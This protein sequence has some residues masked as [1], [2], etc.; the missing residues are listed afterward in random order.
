[1]GGRS[2]NVQYAKL[3]ADMRLI[4]LKYGGDCRACGKELP[5]G[6]R[7][8]WS[9][10]S[11][12]VWCKGCILEWSGSAEPDAGTNTP[13]DR[14]TRL[15]RYLSKCVL[16]EA[17]NTLASYRDRDR[18]WF[19]HYGRSEL[20]VTGE[21]DST[22]VPPALRRH[23]DQR[24]DCTFIYGWPTLVATNQKNH[25]VIAPL[26]LV[27]VRPEHRQG[28]W[29]ADAESEPELNLSIVAGGLFDL[30]M[31]DEIGAV[32]GDGLP[33][34]DP[35]ALVRVASEISRV[36]TVR[37][38]SDLDPQALQPCSGALGLHNAAVWVLADDGHYAHRSLLTE[39]EK[40]ALRRNWTKTAAA[41]LVPARLNLGNPAHQTQKEATAAPL[42]CNGS[43]ELTLERLRRERLTVVTGPPGTVDRSIGAPTPWQG[44]SGGRRFRVR[45]GSSVPGRRKRH[46]RLLGRPD[47]RHLDANRGLGG[48]GTESDQRGCQPR[49]QHIDGP[50]PP[51][52]RC[53][54]EPDAGF[55]A[56]LSSQKT[57]PRRRSES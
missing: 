29:A 26:F 57:G 17:A 56:R 23:L 30:A 22:P 50:G 11:R 53:R 32:V 43:Q 28:R 19:P 27:P 33:F 2:E 4:T 42:P 54:R 15:C 1:M 35:S 12:A 9:R 41:C 51:R 10:S 31:K 13:Q 20:L 49:P 18:R 46:D 36:L 45:N 6:A 47:A 52:N 21:Q 24:N 55:V 39:L 3:P 40:L 7:A 16:A 14:W 8:H 34:G 37:I 25:P 48:T 44:A 38:V 5:R